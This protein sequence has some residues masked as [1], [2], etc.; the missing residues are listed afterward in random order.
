V[1]GGPRHSSTKKGRARDRGSHLSAQGV[2]LARAVGAELGPIA[3]VLTSAAPRAIETAVAMGVAVDNTV[4]LPSGYVPGEVGFHEQWTWAQP[5]V[6]YA[7]LLGRGGGLTAV[8]VA[9]RAAWARGGGDSGRW[10]GRAG[11]VAWRRDRADVGGLPAEADHEHWGALL[12]H[13]GGARLGFA[14]GS[15]VDLRFRRAPAAWISR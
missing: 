6:R 12:G 7:E 15:F 11:R 13:C 9:H 3:Y 2:A 10:R 1:A 5:W 4:D 14:D 8:T